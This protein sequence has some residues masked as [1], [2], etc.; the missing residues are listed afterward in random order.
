MLRLTVILSEIA[1]LRSA[2]A[3][4]MPARKLAG[5]AIAAASKIRLIVIPPPD[6]SAT[7]EPGPPGPFWAA[8]ASTESAGSTSGAGEL[9]EV[10]SDLPERRRNSEAPSQES[11]I[12]SNG[13]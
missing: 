4:S 10:D 3:C 13:W 5:A 12:G 1:E 9:V 7:M 11:S 2:A 8:W 6:V